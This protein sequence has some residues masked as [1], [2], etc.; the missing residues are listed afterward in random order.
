[1]GKP[2]QNTDY[3][4]TNIYIEHNF[5]LDLQKVCILVYLTAN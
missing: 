1:M 4:F 3:L 2:D 5:L